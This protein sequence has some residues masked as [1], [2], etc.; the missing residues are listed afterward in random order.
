MPENL[1]PD[2][3]NSLRRP[4][5]LVTSCLL[6]GQI[7]LFYA[8]PTAEYIPSPPPLSQF[9]TTI[10]PWQSVR[11]TPIESEVEA[12]LKADDTLSRQYASVYGNLDFFVAFFKTQRAGVTPHSP[13]VCL[14]GSGWTPEGDRVISIAVPGEASPIPVNRYLVRHG[15]ERTVVLYWYQG[16]HRVVAN[17]YMSKLYLMLDSLRWHRSDVALVR[18]LSPIQNGDEAHAEK[19]AIDFVQLIYDPLKRQMWR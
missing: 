15:D 12:L 8:I 4:V 16:A 10:G 11:E 14:P 3:K 7:T 17:E 5:V 18:V 9:A 13:K 2:W 6:L 19:T 1:L